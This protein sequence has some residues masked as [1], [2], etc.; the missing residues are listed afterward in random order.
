MPLKRYLDDFARLFYPNICI[1]CGND[2]FNSKNMLCWQCISEL[3][4]TGFELHADNPVDVIFYGRLPL[5]HAFSW[6]YFNKGSLTQHIIHQVKYRKNLE[7]GRYL[8]RL[9]AQAMQ[10][11][12]LYNGIDVLVPLPLN[13]KKMAIRGFNQSMLL[14]EGMAEVLQKP[15]ESVAVLRNR[16]TETQTHKTRL[17]RITNVD[18]VFGLND[19]HRLENKHALL[20][21]DVITTGATMEACG[22]VLCGIPGLQ[23]S[24]ASLAIASKM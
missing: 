3:P 13:K 23:L 6:L 24:M 1:G 18:Q 12:V 11:T 17:Q 21:D 14:C 2:L 16:F 22:Q 7:L 15:I 4:K 9:M 20:V 10:Q 5:V 8:G 19:G